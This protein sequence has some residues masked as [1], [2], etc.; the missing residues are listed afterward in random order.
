MSIRFVLQHN[1]AFSPGSIDS[2]AREYVFEGNL[3]TIGSDAV[4]D[5]VLPGSASEQVVIVHDDENLML[6]N[7][8]EGTRFNGNTL[9][10]EAIEPLMHGDEI[11]IGEYLILVVDDAAVSDDASTERRMAAE[12]SSLSTGSQTRAL[13]LANREST[14]ELLSFDAPPSELGEQAAEVNSNSYSGRN[15]ADVLNALRTEEDSFYFTV[16]SGTQET[17]RLPLELSEMPIGVNSKGE[18]VSGVQQ[19]YGIYA[20]VRKDWSGILLE[21]QKSGTVSVN[22][23]A[24]DQMRRLRNGDRVTFAVAAKFSLVLHEPSSLVALESLLSAR[25]SPNGSGLGS[26]SPAHLTADGQSSVT[27]NRGTSLLERRYFGHFNFTEIVT[28]LIGTLIG[29]VLIFLFLEFMFS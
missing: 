5:I 9:R 2:P 13:V 11:G 7:S 12:D 27:G 14:D 4:N 28:M 19:L 8:A 29:A 18:I 21:S 20:I 1:P 24:L 26:L 6:H 10:R 23:E 17:G 22:G 3:F 15:F 25:N 16:F